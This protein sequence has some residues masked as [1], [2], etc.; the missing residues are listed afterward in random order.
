MA[1]VTGGVGYV[2]AKVDLISGGLSVRRLNEEVCIQQEVPSDRR[3][4]QILK[5]FLVH[6]LAPR[7]DQV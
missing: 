7:T 2:E 3:D 1:R 5:G 6:P 4:Q